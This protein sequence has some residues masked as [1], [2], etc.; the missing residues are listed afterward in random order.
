MCSYQPCSASPLFAARLYLQIESCETIGRYRS[1]SLA[2]SLF[3]NSTKAPLQS[4]TPSWLAKIFIPQ[5]ACR[6]RQENRE[7]V[8][9]T[10]VEIKTDRIGTRWRTYLSNIISWPS[11]KYGLYWF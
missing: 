6:N 10:T 3:C 8:A 5:E 4:H 11:G 1:H 2:H 9:T 7:P